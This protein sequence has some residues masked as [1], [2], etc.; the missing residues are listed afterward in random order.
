MKNGSRMSNQSFLELTN[1]IVN[2]EVLVLQKKWVNKIYS[3]RKQIIVSILFVILS[4]T[5]VRFLE[6]KYSS[7]PIYVSFYIAVAF[8][9]FLLGNGIYVVIINPSLL[10]PIRNSRL[11]LYPLAPADSPFI[12][13]A[14]SAFNRLI[15]GYA[16]GFSLL[17]LIIIELYRFNPFGDDATLPIASS[18]LIFGLFLISYSFLLPNYLLSQIIKNEK[19]RVLENLQS[20]IVDLYRTI[21]PLDIKKSKDIKAITDIYEIVKSSREYPISFSGFRN[22]IT[23]MLLPILSFLSGFVDWK[24][25]LPSLFN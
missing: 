10:I 19:Y 1:Y 7:I 8:A 16:L 14:V 24:I 21:Q 3:L 9:S 11:T 22:Y 13:K 20:K 18:I 6:V 12:T 15:L 2:E 5:I 23:S 17:L 4:L 25:E